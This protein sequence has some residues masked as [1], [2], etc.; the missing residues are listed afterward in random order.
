MCAVMVLVAAVPLAL[1]DTHDVLKGPQGPRA[2]AV[3]WSYSPTEYGVWT[4]KIVNNG[5]R[6]LIV[7]VD[8]N[9]N[10]M[11]ISVLHQRIRFASYDANPVGTV[12]T[13]AA[14]MAA[15]REYMITVTPNGPRGSTCTVEDQ[16]VPAIPPTAVMTASINH[17]DVAVDGSDSYDADGTIVLYEWNFGDGG[18]A[19]GMTATHTYAV[20]GD[21]TITLTV[22]DNDGLQGVASEVVTATPLV[23]PTASFLVVINGLTVDVDGIASSDA[24]GTIVSYDWTFG[25]GGVASGVTATYTYA[26]AGTYLITLKVTDND[27]L[28]GSASQSV[29]VAPIVTGDPVAVMTFT[30]NKLVVSVDGTGS[31]DT[32]GGT[33]VTFDWDFG[34]GAVATGA[35]ATHT[36][37]TWGTWTVALK[38]TDN[39]GKVGMTSM[40]VSVSS[41]TSPPPQ[42]YTVIGYVYDSLGGN[43]FGASIII[44]DART[45]AVWTTATDF[46]YGYYEMN[47]NTNETGW[48]M[49]DIITVTAISGGLTGSAS[50]ETGA[51]GN[52][53]FLYLNVILP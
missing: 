6:S 33:I 31:Y 9:T 37:A 12:I 8:D 14:I 3:T 19:T 4:G 23:P 18:S 35:T 45:G 27:G 30:T 52:E 16:F 43:V 39:D 1:A 42:P 46:V 51:P 21:Y 5:L 44:S 36:Y 26:A 22:T 38:V 53:A 40:L 15:G 11:G 50:G 34:D 32:D 25:D 20:A 47:L 24:D 10:G 29:D 49:G 7:D 2:S 48:A 28:T 17:M 41:P 13:D